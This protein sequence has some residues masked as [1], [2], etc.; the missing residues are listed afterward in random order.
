[1]K[2]LQS[3]GKLGVVYKYLRWEI[4]SMWF[5]EY[6]VQFSKFYLLKNGKDNS[7]VF[8]KFT[9]KHLTIRFWREFTSFKQCLTIS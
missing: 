6:I 3:E 8:L 4:F 7:F 1:M 5:R 2:C 9:M